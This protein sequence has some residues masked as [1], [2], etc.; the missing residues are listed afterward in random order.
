M[1]KSKKLN[2]NEKKLIRTYEKDEKEEKGLW[3]SIKGIYKRD[4]RI[5]GFLSR[6]LKRKNSKKPA[7]KKR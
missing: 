1:A 5:A 2:R 3:Q 6:V 4:S 7:R